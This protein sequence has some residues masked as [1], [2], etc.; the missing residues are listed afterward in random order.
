[1]VRERRLLRAWQGTRACTSSGIVCPD[2]SFGPIDSRTGLRLPQGDVVKRLPSLLQLCAFSILMAV[3]VVMLIRS[4]TDLG[5]G[6]SAVAVRPWLPD[7]SGQALRHVWLTTPDGDRIRLSEHPT[8][9]KTILRS[10]SIVLWQECRLLPR[11]LPTREYTN[12]IFAADNHGHRLNMTD[13]LKDRAEVVL[14]SAPVHSLWI[15]AGANEVDP[16]AF[17]DR[18]DPRAGMVSFRP[19]FLEL[20]HWR[21]G[22]TVSC[23]VPAPNGYRYLA[24]QVPPAAIEQV[25]RG[26]NREGEH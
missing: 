3:L 6:F 16:E 22:I 20:A 1:M 9:A 5:G 11:T 19:C 7:F 15:L 2:P 23:G 25:L 21:P 4:R 8:S 14:P 18:A 10:N 17:A 12:I 26:Q 13:W 24:M